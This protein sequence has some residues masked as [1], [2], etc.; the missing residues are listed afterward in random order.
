DEIRDLAEFVHSYG[1]YLHVDGARISNA[2]AAL[3]CGFKDI[4][5]D[6]G[7]DVI[8]FGGT[9]NG[10][11][12]G[13]AVVFLNPGLAQNVQYVRKQTTQLHSKMRFIAA[14]FEAFF[15]DELW[16]RNAGHSNRM[17]SLL[18]GELESLNDIQITQKVEAN[19]VFAIVP[20]AIIEP[21]QQKYFFY[22]WDEARHE[23]RWMAS[24]DT[25]ETEIMDFVGD[26][27]KLLKA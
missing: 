24:F 18:A 27:K 22:S 3:G 4:T 19:G 5:T 25:T 2:A 23:V 9:K 17:A 21:L 14:Q 8:S 11:M 7:V 26:I 16:R 13:E 20:E 10:L 15:K 1:M 12:F 6:V